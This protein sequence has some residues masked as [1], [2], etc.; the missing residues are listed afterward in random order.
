MSNQILSGFAVVA[1]LGVSAAVLPRVLAPSDTYITDALEPATE[2]TT[3]APFEFIT[4][5]QDFTASEGETVSFSV[6]TNQYSTVVSY[7]WQYALEP[8]GAFIDLPGANYSVYSFTASVGGYYRCL[9]TYN[10]DTIISDTALLTVIPSETEP[11]TEGVT[12]NE[13]E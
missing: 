12:S 11:T 5:P 13:G 1:L 2:I 6:A 4:Q 3:A 10:T 7:Q 9:A 8:V